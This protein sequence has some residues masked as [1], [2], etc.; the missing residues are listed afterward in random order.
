MRLH[1]CGVTMSAFEFTLTLRSDFA[2]LEGREV[3]SAGLLKAAMRSAA[4]TILTALEVP[5]CERDAVRAVCL[6]SPCPLCTLFG[7]RYHEGAL[8]FADL[9]GPSPLLTN[10]TRTPISR[11]RRVALASFEQRV[12]VIP[13]GAELAGVVLHHVNDRALI[14]LGVMALHQITRIGSGGAAGWG[15]CDVRANAM[16]SHAQPYAPARLAEAFS[17]RFPF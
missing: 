3:I 4:G 9:A 11:S 1:Y 16:D 2:L 13:A 6:N 17:A 12:T 5:V 7:S 15:W 14:A 8:H 10:R